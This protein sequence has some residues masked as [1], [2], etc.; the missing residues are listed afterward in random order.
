MQGEQKRKASFGPIEVHA[1]EN[2]KRMIFIKGT[3]AISLL[4]RPTSRE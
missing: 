3:A 4:T 2:C 1:L